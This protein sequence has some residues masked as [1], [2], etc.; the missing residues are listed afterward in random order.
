MSDFENRERWRAQRITLQG[1]TATIEVWDYR[2]C[3][4]V[5]DQIEKQLRATR[6]GRKC[7]C[8]WLTGSQRCKI[9]IAVN[10]Y[11]AA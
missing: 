7:C 6:A 4:P 5:L 8:G 3:R 9:T 10:S 1:D 2:V 11:V